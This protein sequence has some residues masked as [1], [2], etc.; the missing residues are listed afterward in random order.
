MTNHVILAGLAIALL[1]G[2]ASTPETPVQQAPLDPAPDAAA[3]VPTLHA[4]AAPEPVS[5]SCS[6]TV[7][8]GAGVEGG[9]AM[10]YLGCAFEKAASGDLSRFASAIVE[11]AWKDPF[12]TVTGF[13][14]FLVSDSCDL[15]SADPCSHGHVS[16]SKPLIRYEVPRQVLSDFGADGLRAYASFQ[17]V[18]VQQDVAIAVTLVPPGAALP[19]G[20]SALP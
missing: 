15:E 7:N 8:V 1:A 13:D 5:A 9:P 20:H 11:V 16:S 14:F 2:C 17:G 4:D 6:V 10:T 12:P 3:P 18:A 19:A